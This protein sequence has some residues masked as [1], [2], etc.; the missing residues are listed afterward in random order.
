MSNSDEAK[1]IIEKYNIGWI[2]V[3]R[4]ERKNY[5]VNNWGLTQIGKIVWENGENYLIKIN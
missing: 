2:I 4:E 3:G 1:Q 5:A